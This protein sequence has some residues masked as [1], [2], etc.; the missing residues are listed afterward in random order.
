VGVN[1]WK[2]LVKEILSPALQHLDLD[3]LADQLEPYFRNRS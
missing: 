1:P 2:Q 3:E